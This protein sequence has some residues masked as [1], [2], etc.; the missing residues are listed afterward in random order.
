MKK[1]M[2][3]LI[4]C[5]LIALNL[6]AQDT[7]R[8]AA[9]SARLAADT[10]KQTSDTAKMMT[11]LKDSGV[12]K[13][14]TA[15]A[16][17]TAGQ[18]KDAGHASSDT[19]TVKDTVISLVDT[20]DPNAK[21]GDA[22]KGSDAANADGAGKGQ[23]STSDQH[24]STTRQVDTRWFISPLLKLQFQDF[25]MLEKNREGY[26]SNAN[27]LPF[28]ARGN[29][30]FAASAYK[31]ITSRLSV[32]ADLGLSFGHVTNNSVQISQTPSKT[33]NLL[34]A[35]V[36]YHLLPASYRLQPFVEVGINDIINDASYLTVPM[37]IGAKFNSEKVMALAEVSY[38]EA[39]GKNIANTTMY[40]VGVYI[41]IKD[42]KHKQLD[43]DDNTPRTSKKNDRK[44]KDTTRGGNGT[45]IN[46][47]YVTI[48]MDSILRA[49]G[50]LNDDGSPRNGGSGGDGDDDQNGG[51]G[52]RRRRAG[53]KNFD[54]DDF[55][56]NSYKMDSL[57]GQ[58]IIRFVVYFEFNDFGL[59]SRAFESIDRV[60][61]HL[62]KTPSEFSV[63]IKG[64]TD[65]VGND[66]Y[67]NW[68]SRERA[69]MVLKYMNSRG[70]PVE[71]MKAKAYGKDNPVA[72]NGDPSKAWLNRRAE[73]VVHAKEAVANGQ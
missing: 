72:D 30:S 38:G 1:V 56:D 57:D 11:M 46:N 35:T 7:T 4:G 22:S 31:N 42:K 59:T 9:D 63:E 13:P 23:D 49:K 15:P 37:G 34:N 32:S 41:P 18:P 53:L 10:T 52:H 67:N 20:P 70:V 47:I 62:K 69:K 27:T 33:F 24:T 25:A 19:I 28:F 2:I 40:S 55:D 43:I 21:M 54:V 65:S 26:L 68:L 5:F 12:V 64:Y 14:A 50:L 8:P 6:R 60:I 39:I 16:G 73:I 45:V 29:A 48:N 61:G 71:L 51:S 44:D 58:P 3:C 36:Y 66:H 17:D